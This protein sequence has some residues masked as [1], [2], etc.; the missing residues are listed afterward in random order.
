MSSARVSSY[1]V[2]RMTVGLLITSL[3]LGL[4]H[5]ID[6][7]HI[8][9]IADL[10]GSAENRRH[11]FVLS[12]LY[13]LG[14]AVVVF[15][16]GCVAILFG[17]AIPDSLDTWMGR[18]VGATLVG[19]GVW[20]LVEL[21]RKGRNFRLRSR[22][23]L[24][25]DGTFAG[26]RRVRNTATGRHITVE[27]Q[28]DHDHDQSCEDASHGAPGAHDHAHVSAG[29]E[30]PAE[31]ELSVDAEMTVAEPVGVGGFRGRVA[32]LRRHQ[33]THPHAHDLALPDTPDARY[34]HG[35]ATGIGMLHGVGVESPTQ[36]AVF[37]ASTS[38]GGKGLGLV[39]LLG[40]VVGL[41]IAN[42]G[43]ALLAGAGLLKPDRNFAIYATLAVVVAVLSIAMGT[44]F[45]FDLDVLPAIEL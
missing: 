13:A 34:G 26:L 37:V 16:L 14:H 23:M 4:R 8:A 2:A 17:A 24:V 18:I 38:I 31:V 42:S 30:L 7:D 28:H 41:V 15:A 27:H 20:V 39:L 10:S 32:A 11:G 33:H 19:L 22:W 35:T 40:W 3:T 21:G 9:A 36:I 12:F 43:L 25:I 45:L 6:W 29:A 44:L 1:A 5:G